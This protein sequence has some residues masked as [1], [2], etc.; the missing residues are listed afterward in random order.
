MSLFLII[1][2]IL[3]HKHLTCCHASSLKGRHGAFVRL[4]VYRCTLA[5]EPHTAVRPVVSV[6]GLTIKKLPVGGSQVFRF[7]NA[8]PL[9]QL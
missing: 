1:R 8:H 7:R 3:I 5:E 4:E 6:R 2:R 9:E